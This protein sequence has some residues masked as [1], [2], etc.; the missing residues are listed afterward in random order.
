[1]QVLPAEGFLELDCKP[2]WEDLPDEVLLERLE[3]LKERVQ[4]LETKRG[5]KKSFAT[6]LVEDCKGRMLQP[7]RM[8]TLSVEEEKARV[9]AGWQ[10]FDHA[11]HLAAFGSEEELGKYV[12]NPGQL[13]QCKEDL[14]IGFSDQIP[15]WVKCP[16]TRQVYCE[17]EV[18]KTAAKS[19]KKPAGKEPEAKDSTLRRCSGD[20]ADEKCRITYEARQLILNYLKPGTTPA[21]VVAAGALVVKG[22]HARLHNID[23]AG[24][25]IES[26]SFT[27]AGREYCRTAGKSAGRVLLPWRRARELQ[28]DLVADL[29]VYSQP[30][31]V[32]DGVI[33]HWIICMQAKMYPCSVWCRDTLSSGV[34]VTAR[35]A[36]A[37][38]LQIPCYVQGHCTPLVQITD[39]DFSFS[40]KA[41]AKTVQSAER[42]EQ[43]A[44]AKLLGVKPQFKCGARQIL[45]ICSKSQALQVERQRDR[46]WILAAARR[47]GWLAWRPNLATGKLE[48]CSLQDWAADLR[49]G[50]Y[51]LPSEWLV[52]RLQWLD[53]AGVPLKPNF[54]TFES[55]AALAAQQEADYCVQLGF[56]RHFAC[57]E[58]TLQSEA[59]ELECDELE[60]E[61]CCSLQGRL[62]QLPP[63]LRRRALKADVLAADVL[64][65]DCRRQAEIRAAKLTS[66]VFKS[67]GKL[68]LQTLLQEGSRLQALQSLHVV[69]GKTKATKQKKANPLKPS[70]LKKKSKKLEDQKKRGKEK[71]RH[72]KEPEDSEGEKGCQLC[73]PPR[74]S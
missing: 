7:G 18:S 72:Q 9:K 67:T 66:R 43:R 73:F 39:T 31:A 45:K 42:Q 25:W 35:K 33:M 37:L 5:Y 54:G 41:G 65:K 21:G 61:V 24:N 8:S 11:L 22:I 28:P 36:M 23:A 14:V 50:C 47:N 52:E 13:L 10:Q 69:A 6:R 4:R 30:A 15:F 64:Q 34:A 44:A 62:E 68:E 46:P 53:E 32:V 74:R 59:V 71:G 49:L 16:R 2:P 55:A 58:S 19:E 63:K 27:Y 3:A 60:A 70:L 26:E 20:A 17:A 12:A 51:R 40:F 56:K 48:D 1:M 38:A 29:E 57:L